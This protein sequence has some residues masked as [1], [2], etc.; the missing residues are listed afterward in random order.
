MIEAE[1]SIDDVQEFA[2]RN[3]H[4]F[5][6]QVVAEH[7]GFTI[8]REAWLYRASVQLIQRDTQSFVS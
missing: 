5:N 1:S 3:L 2:E 4:K 7:V 8:F 6:V